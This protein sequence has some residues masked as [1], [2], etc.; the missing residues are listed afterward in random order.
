MTSIA[1]Q[2]ENLACFKTGKF[3]VWQIYR[4]Q[5]PSSGGA[6]QTVADTMATRAVTMATSEVTMET[7]EVTH[8]SSKD[9]TVSETVRGFWPTG[10]L[11]LLP[12]NVSRG[13]VNCTRYT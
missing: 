5:D 7:R 4:P 9:G 10:S 1:Q 11:L 6:G 12:V 8:G 3:Q 2:I 13:S